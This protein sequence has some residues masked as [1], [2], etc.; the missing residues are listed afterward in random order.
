MKST[1]TVNEKIIKT[2]FVF[3]STIKP[4]KLYFAYAAR[5]IS[6]ETINPYTFD[7]KNH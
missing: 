1:I 7:K 2:N 3:L 6:I 5:I 4:L